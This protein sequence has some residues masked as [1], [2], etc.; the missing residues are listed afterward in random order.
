M[1]RNIAFS[2]HRWV[3][4]FV[5]LILVIVGL[6]G[7]LLV[8]HAELDTQ[9]VE[10]RFGRIVPQ[11]QPVTA[12][13]I[14]ESVKAT[15]ANHP[16]WQVGQL[17][18]TPHQPFYTVRL[19]RPDQTLWEV[20][21]NPYTGQVI[22]DRQRETALFSRILALHYSL[23]GGEMGIKVVGVAALL[24]CLLSVTGLFL[25]NGWRKLI[26]G[27]TVKWNA[28][29]KRVNYDL[30]N[31]I[32]IVSV[33]FLSA[34]AFTG[35]CWTFYD[36]AEPAI[37]TLTLTPK[38]PEFRSTPG[39]DQKPL[40]LDEILQ[41]SD[42]A[43]PNAIT[44]SI[45]FPK[46][47]EGVFEIYKKRPDNLEDFENSVTVDPFTGKV[48]Y[49]NDASAIAAKVLN[50]FTPVHYGTFGGILTRSFYVLI[51]L[52]PTLLFVTGFVMYRYRR[53]T[54]KSEIPQS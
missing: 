20:F 23:L 6:T 51:G 43:L 46:G 18:M 1:L 36:Q 4:L 17:Q 24:L 26:A 31:V 44:T 47:A 28:H 25:W 33:A 16:D 21:V 30:H 19:L 34:I 7:S 40:G 52:S 2:L 15:Y 37:Y 49:V 10:S 3:G 27:F 5:G 13:Q 39:K 22:G 38:P 45:N 32:G 54:A 35:F 42:G 8:F 12:Q 9:L 11:A 48:L 14:V 53:R 29:P 41:Q 50:S